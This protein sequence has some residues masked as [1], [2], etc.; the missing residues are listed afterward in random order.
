MKMGQ[1]FAKSC[2]ITTRLSVSFSIQISL[3]TPW[4]VCDNFWVMGVL[5]VFPESPVPMS[6]TCAQF[7]NSFLELRCSLSMLS[8]RRCSWLWLHPI[9]YGRLSP[10]LRRGRVY[11]SNGEF[12]RY[13]GQVFRFPIWMQNLFFWVS[14]SR[15]SYVSI[16]LAD[17]R[18]E[19][20]RGS[21]MLLKHRS[22][23]YTISG[24]YT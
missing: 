7:S 22:N 21:N 5:L 14:F 12:R 2:L 15:Q 23:S 19:R 10:T 18:F 16:S 9:L 1:L 24:A 6:R 17:D 20:G 4:R 13:R 8:L 3:R 11:P